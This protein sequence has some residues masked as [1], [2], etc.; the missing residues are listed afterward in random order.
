[1]NYWL[2]RSR[3]KIGDV[4]YSIKNPKLRMTVASVDNGFCHCVWFNEFNEFEDDIF[5]I[6]VLRK[7]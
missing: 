1:M 3:F 4:V 7:N 6:D 5:P 2:N